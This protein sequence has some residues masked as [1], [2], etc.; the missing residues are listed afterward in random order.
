[1]SSNWTKP[2]RVVDLLMLCETIAGEKNMH[3]HP[4]DK[5]W[6]YLIEFFG[7]NDKAYMDSVGINPNTPLINVHLI[8][9]GYS[10]NEI[11]LYWI[12]W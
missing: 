11:I 12:C 10:E 9:N 8:A 3:N 6:Q 1:M 2:W 7:G 5:E 4:V